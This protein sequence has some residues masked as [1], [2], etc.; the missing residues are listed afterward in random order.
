MST[1][2]E[3]LK[4]ITSE[5]YVSIND[6]LWAHYAYFKN[7]FTFNR[8]AGHWGAWSEKPFVAPTSN[9]HLANPYSKG[10]EF[11]CY[12]HVSVC[13]NGDAEYILAGTDGSLTY[14]W[15]FGVH[16]VENGWGYLPKGVFNR[17][18]HND[19]VLCCIL[20]KDDK[21]PDLT[22]NFEVVQ[23]KS[24]PIVLAQDYAFA[25]VATGQAT[26]D[27]IQYNQKQNIQ[28]LSSGNQLDMAVNTI[29]IL[30]FEV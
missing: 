14:D 10:V 23:T 21:D 20:F 22:Y 15:V 1:I 19:F 9:Y 28:N 13:V 26:Y 2:V 24:A 25:H 3:K 8:P 11:G 16:N 29:V 4:P 5:E 18:F 30:G 7:G 6:S 12:E 27:G 17:V